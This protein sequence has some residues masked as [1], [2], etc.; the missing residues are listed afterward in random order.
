MSSI[1]RPGEWLPKLGSNRFY[2]SDA[3]WQKAVRHFLARSAAGVIVVG[4]STG[5]RW[6]RTALDEVPHERLLFVFP[7][8][9]PGETDVEVGFA[10]GGC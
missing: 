1:G 5:L 4:R 8:L 7:Y 9:L 2:S 10:L 6:D 3:E